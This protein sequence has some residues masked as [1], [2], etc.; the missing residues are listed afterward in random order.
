MQ[1]LWILHRDE[2]PNLTTHSIGN[3][4]KITQ[5]RC[6]FVWQRVWALAAQWCNWM[7]NADIHNCHLLSIHRHLCC[8]WHYY[9]NSVCG[10]CGMYNVHRLPR[11]NKL[12]QNFPFFLH[13]KTDHR[14]QSIQ[15]TFFAMHFWWYIYI[16]IDSLRSLCNTVNNWYRQFNTLFEQ[17]NDVDDD[18]TPKGKRTA[19]NCMP[20][21]HDTHRERTVNC[22]ISD[23]RNETEI[24]H[25]LG[26]LY[27]LNY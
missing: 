20:K 16:Y 5:N 26:N 10:V 4:F 19:A 1:L 23:V 9:A 11:H 27:H 15:N 18:D 24:L 3:G 12:R 22:N 13:S 25:T 17:Y 21:Q 7:T 14:M 8:G 6:T 2:N